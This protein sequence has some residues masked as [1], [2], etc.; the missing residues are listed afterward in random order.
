MPIPTLFATAQA[1]EFSLLIKKKNLIRQGT[2]GYAFSKMSN[3]AGTK[4]IAPN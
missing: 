2:A 3:S 1:I 4:L